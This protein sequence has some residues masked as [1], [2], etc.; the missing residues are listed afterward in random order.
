MKV[1]GAVIAGGRSRR[2][3]RDKA[4]AELYGASLID[5]SLAVLR[6]GCAVVAVNGPAELATSRGVPAIEDDPGLPRGPAAG[7]AGVLVWADLRGYTH[8]VTAPC[9]TPRLPPD[10]VLRLV[11]HA[12]IAPVLAARAERPHP[13]CA[14]WRVEALPKLRRYFA[15]SHP[16]LY[17]LVEEMGGRWLQFPDETAFVNVNTERDLAQLQARA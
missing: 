13:L 8:V 2:F 4:Q 16:P 7:L 10:L 17:A 14:I 12:G 1:A 6:A 5:L 11:A 3:G 15:D 9:D